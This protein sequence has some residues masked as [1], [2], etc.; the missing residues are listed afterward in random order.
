MG[1]FPSASP[2]ARLRPV[3]VRRR[4]RFAPRTNAP[5]AAT[6][7]GLVTRAQLGTLE[8]LAVEAGHREQLR[9]KATCGPPQPRRRTV[10]VSGLQVAMETHGH[11]K[12]CACRPDRLGRDEAHRLLW[13]LK[14][15]KRRR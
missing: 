9:D 6:A 10:V 1:L 5:G 13:E 8:R 2:W 7:T 14:L 3:P 4:A 12:A 11:G 15:D